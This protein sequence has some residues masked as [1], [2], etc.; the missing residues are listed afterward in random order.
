[1]SRKAPL[2]QR[3]DKLL[4]DRGLAD[5]RE[6]AKA[7]ILSGNVLVN[8]T[9][10]DKA[11]SLISIDDDLT[12]KSRMPYVSRGGLKL[13]HALSEFNIDVKGLAAMDAGASTGG[14]TDCLLQH[15][16][17]KVFAVDVG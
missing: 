15:G 4:F 2:K 5:S 14:F 17:S 10:I 8:G 11:G 13:E 9:V 1:M 6:K 16:A 12:L 7:L 3:L